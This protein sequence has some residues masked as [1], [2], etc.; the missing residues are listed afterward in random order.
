MSVKDD[1]ILYLDV[2]EV[3]GG[4]NNII[5]DSSNE[6]VSNDRLTSEQL[7]EVSDKLKSLQ[8]S[9][10]DTKMDVK[11]NDIRARKIPDTVEESKTHSRRDILRE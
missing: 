1:D 3:L 10:N 7:S 6:I 2:D 4:S 8:G 9:S 5:L 11:I